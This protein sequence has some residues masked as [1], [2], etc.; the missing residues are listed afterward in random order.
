MCPAIAKRPPFPVRAT[1]HG[2][3]GLIAVAIALLAV[4]TI[5]A[6][7]SSPPAIIQQPISQAALPEANVDFIVS[8]TGTSPLSYQWSFDGSPI[9]GATNALF[10]ISGFRP[11]NAGVYSAV[12]T[13]TGGSVT[14][15]PVALSLAQPPD[16][17][18]ARS[19]GNGTNGPFTDNSVVQSVA[20]DASGN[21]YSAGYFDA[22]GLD[23]GGLVL[24]NAGQPYVNSANFLCRYDNS[25]NFLWAT[26]AGTNNGSSLPL[27]VANDSS[28]NAYLAGHFTAE[29]NF[30]TNSIV[31]ATS[32]DI[33]VAKYSPQGQV[34]WVTQISAY[35]TNFLNS[36]D[37]GFCVDGTGNAFLM[38][39]ASGSAGFGTVTLTNSHGFL[40]KYDSGGNLVWAQQTSS[41]AS[42][43]ATGANGAVYAASISGSLAKYDNLGN[44]LWSEPFPKGLALALDGKENIYA[45]GYGTGVFNGVTLTNFAGLPDFF[46]AKCDPLGN[47]LWIRNLGGTQMKLGTGIALDAL[48]N[49]YISCMSAELT[50]EPLISCGSTVLSNVFTFVAKYDPS[51]NA[52]WAQPVVATNGSCAMCIAANDA[53]HIYAGGYSFGGTVFFGPFAFQNT[54]SAFHYKMFFITKLAGSNPSAAAVLGVL[55]VSSGTPFRCSVTGLPGF[56]YAVQASADLISW[57]TLL[58]N[59]SPFIF[60]DTNAVTL[61]QRFYRSVFLP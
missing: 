8:A 52:L 25:G 14:S 24:T 59:A 45:T 34:L 28:G 49:A 22:P 39:G 38:S 26:S 9:G 47:C 21:V 56:N 15:S 44:L 31:S 61:P 40:A 51:G 7:I 27:L 11:T 4:R 30:G 41:G 16:F 60:V 36:L 53:Q 43:I 20:V 29:A 42:A 33:F 46:V 3:F 13:N 1:R 37:F 58:T 57:T 18:W 17:L 50:P 6:Q 48:G 54:N 12:I 19:A 5:P 23:F 2:I 35:D 55:P 32:A 10:V